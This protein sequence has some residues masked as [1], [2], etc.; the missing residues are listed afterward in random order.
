[1]HSKDSLSVV[2]LG[3]LGACTAACFAFKGHEVIGIDINPAA[4]KSIQQGKAPVYEPGLQDLITGSAGRFQAT[5]VIEEAISRSD[6]TFF[7]TPTPSQ[8]DGRFS[9]VHLKAALEPMAKAL[10]ASS[11]PYH[12]FVIVSTTSPGTVESSL[13]PLIEK[14]SGRKL[15]AGFGVAYNPEF[16]ALGTVVRDFL[17]PD[18]L[19]IG[20]S[21]KEA[22]DRV[23]QV[24]KQVVNNTPKVARMAIVSAEIAKLSL[25]AFV[26]TKI[27]FANT[28]ANICEDVP[29]ADIDAITQA[30]GA[31]RR[32]SPYAIKGGSAFGGPC[33]PRDN[34]AFQAFA[35]EHNSEAELSEATD[36][37]NKRQ[38]SNLTA[39]VISHLNASRKVS[40]LGVA[41]KSDTPVIEEAPG[42]KLA[43][44]LLKANV[45]VCVYDQLALENTKAEFGDKLKYASS[46]EDCLQ[47]SSVLVITTPL[48]E[49]KRFFSNGIKQKLTL[50][51]CWR[52]F[53]KSE[54]SDQIKYIAVGRVS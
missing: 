49:F 42:A 7:V 45:D 35:R 47:H 3:K 38:I 6:I 53:K 14:V 10:K 1:M 26:T 39:K 5:T 52:S 17:N 29:G 43:A 13:I 51:D 36:K 30:I 44:E 24:Y 18:L 31:D 54:L 25:N 50:I 40:I 28:L 48:D 21:D 16:I 9:D 23:E 34:R 27:S 8:P 20:E 2:G 32:V 41:Y 11:K 12:L 37:V 46:I 33:F 4:V 15:N 19:L 22:G